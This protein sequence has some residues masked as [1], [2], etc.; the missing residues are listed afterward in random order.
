[1]GR[2]G[3]V[4]SFTRYVGTFKRRDGRR[5]TGD[6]AFQLGFPIL[7]GLTVLVNGWDCQ[8]AQILAGAETTV[9]IVSGLICGLAIMVFQLRLQLEEPGGPR[10]TTQELSRVDDLFY[11]SVWSIL[12]GFASAVLLGLLGRLPWFHNIV[13]F[14]AVVFLTNFATSVLMCINYLYDAYRIVRRFSR[15]ERD[16]SRS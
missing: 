4:S 7:F 9:S 2:G 14:S 13:A 5:N 16:E 3:V 11:V 10:V 6:Y 8:V 1:M 15:R 12:A